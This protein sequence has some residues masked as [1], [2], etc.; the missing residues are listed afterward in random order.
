MQAHEDCLLEWLSDVQNSG[1][2]GGVAKNRIYCPQ[3]KTEIKV[4]KPIELVVAVTDLF[5][6]IGRQLVLPAGAA[7]IIG[8]LYS[9]SMAYGFN[10]IQLIFGIEETQAMLFREQRGRSMLS[11]LIPEIWI[12]RIIDKVIYFNPF[13]PNARGSLVFAI[14]PLIAPALLLSK[15]RLAD[16]VFQFVPVAV[17][18]LPHELAIPLLTC[19]SVPSI[20][21]KPPATL[22]MATY[23]WPCLRDAALHPVKLSITLRQICVS[24]RKEMGARRTT[25][26]KGRRNDG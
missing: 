7:M 17:R 1:S 12:S 9:G 19:T 25:E 10:T 5:R 15:S 21:H 14:S 13:I 20:P 3:C 26:T 23:P 22:L 4:K 16:R 11:E 6:A 18:R 2:G 8:C 24:S